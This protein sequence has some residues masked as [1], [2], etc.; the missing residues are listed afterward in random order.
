MISLLIPIP[1]PNDKTPMNEKCKQ[2]RWYSLFVQTPFPMLA[3]SLEKI[4]L[5]SLKDQ[6][7]KPRKCLIN[8]D[9]RY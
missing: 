2:N 4:S 8:A 9:G 1:N 3:A 5:K 6:I 7:D